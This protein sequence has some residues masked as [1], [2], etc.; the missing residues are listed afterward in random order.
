MVTSA[1]GEQPDLTVLN[2][3]DVS[4]TG[5]GLGADFEDEPAQHHVARTALSWRARCGFAYGEET[6]RAYDGI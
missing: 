5:E 3:A 2:D 4:T 1:T 6:G